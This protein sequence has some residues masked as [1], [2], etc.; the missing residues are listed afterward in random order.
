MCVITSDWGGGM[1]PITQ[2]IV[3]VVHISAI[4]VY[5][6]IAPAYRLTLDNPT[7]HRDASD[8]F[9]SSFIRGGNRIACAFSH[10]TL[11]GIVFVSFHVYGTAHQWNDK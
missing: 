1:Y 3:D 4:H 5:S 6:Y 7:P 9:D 2:L 8:D 10:R 11:Q